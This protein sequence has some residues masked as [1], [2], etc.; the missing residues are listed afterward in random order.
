MSITRRL[1]L[2]S[3]LALAACGKPKP[4]L[5]AMS[6]DQAKVFL[7]NNAKQPGVV[8]TKSG[9]EY[10]IL[11]SGPADGLH[12]KP[13]DEVKVNYE[14]R[15]TTGEVFDSS[16]KRG[17]PATMVVGG[18]VPGWIE[19]LELMRPGDEWMLWLPPELGYKDADNGPIPA[20]SV[21]VFKLELIAVLSDE[22]S[23]GRG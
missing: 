22:T 18:L 1:A 2:A 16:Y 23:V 11:R 7:D 8:R 21:L 13:A 20:N 3:A 4:K 17:V 12:P 6:P 14:G 15:L 9:L 10:K 19:A 5:V